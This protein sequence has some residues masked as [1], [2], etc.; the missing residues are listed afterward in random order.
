MAPPIEGCFGAVSLTQRTVTPPQATDLFRQAGYHNGRRMSLLSAQQARNII[1]AAIHPHYGGHDVLQLQGFTGALH[2]GM[3]SNG[4][5]LK[6]HT[7]SS[8]LES[9]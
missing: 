4:Q 6:T 5:S 1:R 7:H 8:A 3:V 2:Q 9:N